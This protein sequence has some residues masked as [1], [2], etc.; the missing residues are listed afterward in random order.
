MLTSFSIYIEHDLWIVIGAC[1]GSIIFTVNALEFPARQRLMLFFVSLFSGIVSVAFVAYS[2]TSII[3]HVIGINVVMPVPV[4]VVIASSSIERILEL[5][6]L[7]PGGVW[8][9]VDYV[10]KKHEDKS[11]SGYVIRFPIL[12]A[13]NLFRGGHFL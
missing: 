5:L 3:G 4:G 6:F 13:G 10:I 8:L 1:C 11:G 12:L 2:L 9:I 7:K